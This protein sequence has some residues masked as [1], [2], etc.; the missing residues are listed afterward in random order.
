[1]LHTLNT[2]HD[3]RSIFSAILNSNPNKKIRTFLEKWPKKWSA[4]EKCP[5]LNAAKKCNMTRFPQ[6]RV[7]YLNDREA[8]IFVRGTRKHSVLDHLQDARVIMSNTDTPLRGRVHSGFYSMYKKSL[9]AL[10]SIIDNFNLKKLTI[11]GVSMGAAIALM[12]AVYL[13]KTRPNLNL[14]LITAL[15]PPVGDE[16]FMKEVHKLNKQVHYIAKHD[17]ISALHLRNSHFS[18]TK[19]ILKKLGYF[20]LIHKH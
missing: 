14:S 1:M 15:L 12:F 8:I 10:N 17:F 5:T 7:Q 16:T 19:Q 2:K 6:I 18:S 11:I 3:T 13:R 4:I 9:G 20:P